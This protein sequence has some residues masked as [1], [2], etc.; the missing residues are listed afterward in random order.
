[1]SSIVLQVMIHIQDG[2]DVPDPSEVV[3]AVEDILL[4][5]GELSGQLFQNHRIKDIDVAFEDVV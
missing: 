3:S 1:M 2:H 5:S 4:N